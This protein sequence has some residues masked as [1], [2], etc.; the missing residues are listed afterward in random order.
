MQTLQPAG[1]TPPIGYTNGIAA[2][3]GRVVFVDGQVGW[4]PNQVF[5]SE[6]LAPQFDQALANVLAAL[7]RPHLLTRY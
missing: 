3:P 4:D 1:W 7:S 5:H 2:G 6:D